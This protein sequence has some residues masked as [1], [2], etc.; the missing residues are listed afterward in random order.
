ME[1]TNIIVELALKGDNFDVQEI[2]NELGIDPVQTWNKGEDIRQTG[3]KYQ[4]TLW[5][6]DIGPIYT[7]DTRVAVKQLEKLFLKKLISC[8]N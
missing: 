5:E 4:Y 1:K 2:T 3:K 8:V 6:Y 7:L